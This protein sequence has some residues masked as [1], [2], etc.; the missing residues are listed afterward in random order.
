MRRTCLL[1]IPIVFLSALPCLAQGPPAPVQE[2]K[3][4]YA[5][6]GSLLALDDHTLLIEPK[7]PGPICALPANAG[8]ET[9]WSLFTFPLAS[10]TIPL[11]VVDETLIAEDVVFTQPDARETYKPGDV[12]DTTMVVI[13]SLPGKQFHT[14][15]YDRDRLLQL[16]PGP[17]DPSVYGQ[18]PDDVEAF[19]LTFSDH[20]AASA[21]VAAFRRAVIAAKAGI[22]HQPAGSNLN[23]SEES[24]ARPLYR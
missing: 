1:A 9:T 5:A 14:L 15:T 8:G 6:S 11:A 2:M 22:A 12:G 16:G 17:H 23:N 3:I 19:G 10:I 7:M 4:S 18:A 20:E 24:T 13:V 21:F